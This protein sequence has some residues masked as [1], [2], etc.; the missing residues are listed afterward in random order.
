M[1]KFSFAT[2]ALALKQSE[3]GGLAGEGE[4]GSWRGWGKGDDV[5]PSVLCREQLGSPTV[6][7]GSQI[8]AATFPGI[9][10][11]YGGGVGLKGWG[12]LR[13]GLR[14]QEWSEGQDKSNI[15]LRP[16]NQFPA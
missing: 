7:Y 8:F 11:C 5:S 14:G 10:G 12:Q 4:R 9:R 13:K 16:L 3:V 1:R 15:S 2:P 6:I